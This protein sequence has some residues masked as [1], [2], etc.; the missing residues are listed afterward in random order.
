[1]SEVSSPAPAPQESAESISVES[2]PNQEG[3]QSLPESQQ[4]VSDQ[5]PEE[6]IQEAVENGEISKKEANKLIK[7]FKLKVDGKEFTKTVDLS[8]EDFLRQQLIL[9]E[10]AR[11]RMSETA[12]IKKAFQA[13]MGR[14]KQDPWSVMKDLGL[15]PDELAEMRIQQRIEEMK[16]SPEQLAQEKIQKEL[17][18]AREEARRLKEE[19]E[20]LEMSKLQEQAAVQLEEEIMGALDGHRT[21]PKSQY[22]VKRIADSMLWAMNNGFGDVTAEDVVPLVEK[23]M[24]DELNRFMDEMPEDL[25]EKYIGQRNIDRLRKRRVSAAKAAI[26]S[27]NDIKPT[28]KSLAAEKA[29]EKSKQKIPARDFW[30]KLGK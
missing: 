22:V 20:Q 13:E 26:P 15:D 27:V 7:E 10:T 11:S 12:N 21:L 8:D 24:R 3:E 29:P 5:S 14:L 9:A 25:M 23:E 6:A 4:E 18:E 16:K 19:K 2:Q 17:Q 1:M 30:K 28:N